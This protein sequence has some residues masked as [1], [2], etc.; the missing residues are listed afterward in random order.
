MVRTCAARLRAT[1]GVVAGCGRR[2]GSTCVASAGFPDPA[3]A[4]RRAEGLFLGGEFGRWPTGARS[5][6]R[7]AEEVRLDLADRAAAELDE[8]AARALPP[9]LQHVAAEPRG[10]V[11]GDEGGRLGEHARLRDRGA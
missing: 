3:L 5:R 1:D 6:R 4:S 7:P 2:S 10:D 8:A 9:P 11:V